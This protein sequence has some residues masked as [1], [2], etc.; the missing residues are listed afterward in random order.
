MGQDGVEVAGVGEVE[1][2]VYQDGAVVLHLVVVDGDVPLFGHR[3]VVGVW[4]VGRVLTG[5]G[6]LDEPVDPAGAHTRRERRGLRV[7]PRHRLH[8]QGRGGVDGGLGDDPGPPR[9]DPAGVDLGPQPGQP[10]S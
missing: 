9:G 6:V 7:D 10:V 2:G 4:G 8:G 1:A 3:R 5:D